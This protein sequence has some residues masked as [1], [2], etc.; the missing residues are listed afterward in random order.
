M[1]FKK[2]NL[3]WL[4]LDV[5]EWKKD[6]NFAM[7]FKTVT[8]IAVVNDCAERFIK[9]VSENIMSVRSEE[10]LTN[11]IVTVAELHQLARDLNRNSYTKKELELTIHKVLKL[12]D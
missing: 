7:L 6:P 9:L 2:A 1:H 3:R 8:K 5:S 12:D 11:R 4:E 10:H